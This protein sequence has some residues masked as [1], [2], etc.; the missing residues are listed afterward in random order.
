MRIV[1]WLLV[2]PAAFAA[3][4]GA[5]LLGLA[6][7]NAL[8]ALCPPDLMISGVC[9]AAWHPPAMRVLEAVCAAVAAAGVV[10][11]PALIAP[12]YRVAVA[13]ICFFA[14]AAFA[15]FM[16]WAGG[17]WIALAAAALSG[18]TV[19]YVCVRRWRAVAS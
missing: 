19:W 10:V 3:W 14:G 15:V 5:L 17:L 2:P 9:T 1:R 16:A 8:D 4:V 13:T 11:A 18:T 6:G 7:I 12:A